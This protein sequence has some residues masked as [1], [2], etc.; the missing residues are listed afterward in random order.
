MWVNLLL[1]HPGGLTII[2]FVHSSS[3]ET[4]KYFF[5]THSSSFF[6]PTATNDFSLHYVMDLPLVLFSLGNHHA[7][8]TMKRVRHEVEGGEEEEEAVVVA[9]GE[10]EEKD[11]EKEEEEEEEKEK[12]DSPSTTMTKWNETDAKFWFNVFSDSFHAFLACEDFSHQKHC[13][14]A[15]KLAFIA[16][17]SEC[18]QTYV[19]KQNPSKYAPLFSGEL[20]PFLIDGIDVKHYFGIFVLTRDRVV[21]LRPGI[22]TQKA[23]ARPLFDPHA[24]PIPVYFKRKWKRPNEQLAKSKFAKGDLVPYRLTLEK[25]E[26]KNTSTT[27]S[28]SS[29]SSSFPNEVIILT[30]DIQGLHKFNRV[31][32][33]Y[34]SSFIVD[35]SKE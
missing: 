21:S 19:D 14:S 27:A 34:L 30:A 26:S 3:R 5:C 22:Y 32:E 20:S 23:T 25:K 28:P 6:S 11:T 12:E 15:L 9:V 24:D 33:K 13:S 31:V 2:P 7:R 10:D 1:D 4:S 29:S 35:Q 8:L 16:S 17:S 18:I